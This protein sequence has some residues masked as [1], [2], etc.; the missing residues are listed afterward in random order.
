M[1]VI[2]GWASAMPLV[3]ISLVLHAL[4]VSL[5]CNHVS[6]T[7]HAAVACGTWHAVTGQQVDAACQTLI[8]LER[9]INSVDK[10]AH[11]CCS[12]VQAIARCAFSARIRSPV[13]GFDSFTRALCSEVIA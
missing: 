13:V 1:L 10:R 5:R 8:C 2:H 11:R 3:W 7:W 12:M 6:S 4:W 9:F